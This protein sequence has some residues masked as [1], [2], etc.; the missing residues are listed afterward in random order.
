[1]IN[2]LQLQKRCKTIYI[3]KRKKTFFLII[4]FDN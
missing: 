1:M 3:L 2:E 4:T